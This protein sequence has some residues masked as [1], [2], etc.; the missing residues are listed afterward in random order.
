MTSALDWLGGQH[1]G[2][3]AFTP[4]KDPVPVVQEVGWAPGAG[5]DGCGKSRST[6]IRSPDLPA[7]ASRKTDSDIPAH[8]MHGR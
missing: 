5:L 4:G 1:H 3:A 8:K 7:L 6:G 2:P